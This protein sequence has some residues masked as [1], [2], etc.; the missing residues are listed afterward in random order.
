MQDAVVSSTVA[1]LV[2]DGRQVRGGRVRRGQGQAGGVVPGR[3]DDLRLAQ[4]H[5]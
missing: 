1:L 5:C 3:L 2:E 4:A